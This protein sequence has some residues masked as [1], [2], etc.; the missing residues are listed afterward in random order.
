ME[1]GLLIGLLAGIVVA[2]TV[3]CIAF[4]VAL[5]R[6]SISMHKREERL[7]KH[8]ITPYGSGLCHGMVVD[9]TNKHAVRSTQRKSQAWYSRLA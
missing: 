3:V 2:A 1:A 6:K 8:G 5:L 4:N 9:K 7:L